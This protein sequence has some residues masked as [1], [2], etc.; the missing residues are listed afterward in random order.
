MEPCTPDFPSA[1]AVKPSGCTYRVEF[2][3]ALD[4]PSW[5]PLATITATGMSLV[6]ADSSGTQPERY[7]RVVLLP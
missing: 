6:V 5:T 4:D 2:K 7:Y 1:R 3:D